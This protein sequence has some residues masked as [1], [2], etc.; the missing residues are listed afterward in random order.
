MKLGELAGR[1]V[2]DP[3]KLVAYA[4]NADAPRGRHKALV[5]DRAL[6]IKRNAGSQPV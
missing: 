1:I 3:R 6:G 4:L 5:F 2:S